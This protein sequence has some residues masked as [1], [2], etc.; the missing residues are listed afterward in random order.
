MFNKIITITLN[1]SL[2]TTLWVDRFDLKEPVSAIRE[3]I[4]PGGKS[5]NVTRVLTALGIKSKALGFVGEQNIT[6]FIQLLDQ[7]EISYHFISVKGTIRENFSIVMPN[8]ELFK[9]NRAGFSVEQSVLDSLQSNI[10][11]EIKDGDQVLLVFAG[12]LPKNV[13]KEQ[14]K[15][16]IQNLSDEGIQIAIDTDIFT[17]QDIKELKPYIMKPNEVE[18]S[19]LA[20]T[21]NMNE[22]ATCEYAKKLSQYATHVLVSRGDEGL[23]Y[24]GNNELIQCSVPE[25]E[26]KSTVGAGDTTLA[27]FIKALK[28]ELPIANCVQFA[29]ACG[30]A[31]VLLEGTGVI[32]LEAANEMIND[33]RV[34]K[35][36]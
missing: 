29:A 15:T 33:I 24:A 10:E 32:S 9:V 1:P 27:G 4:Y 31:S 6:T 30:T 2:D 16:L 17:E 35:L 36:S 19:H 7:E 12:S 26:V 21:E 11:S 28:E 18:L 22:K 20:K 13:S 3:Q 25:V 23:L 14:Y 34:T 5:I 8:G